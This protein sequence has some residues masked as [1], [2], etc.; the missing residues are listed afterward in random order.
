M[1]LLADGPLASAIWTTLPPG[2]AVATS[3][4]S[5]SFV[6]PMGRGTVNMIGRAE[7]IH[8]GSQ[9]GLSMVQIT[10]QNGRLLAF[11]STRCLI[12]DG[13]IAM[14]SDGTPTDPGPTEPADPYLRPPP[15]DGY[16]SFD[17]L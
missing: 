17:Q 12:S 15:E 13:P 10:D 11:G 3:E 4:L 8:C 6:R 7:S 1:A 9:V 14:D 5:L 2:K 16:F